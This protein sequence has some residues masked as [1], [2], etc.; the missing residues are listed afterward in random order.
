MKRILSFLAVFCVCIGVAD[1]A[2]RAT[3]SNVRNTNVTT[4]RNA[5]P[6]ND[7]QTVSSRGTVTRTTTTAQ[8]EITPRTATQKVSRVPVSRSA[9]TA[10]HSVQT[11]ARTSVARGTNTTQSSR[12][13]RATTLSDSLSIG[14]NACRDAYFTCM[15]QFC[16]NANDTYRRCIC[17]SRLDEIK[18]KFDI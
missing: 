1:A 15:D 16:A 17:S 6:R 3:N 2:V 14:Y 10:S 4:S 12:I 11:N 18:T 5:K 13:S 8:R 7:V 9:T